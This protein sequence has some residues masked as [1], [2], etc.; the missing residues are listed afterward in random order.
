MIRLLVAELLQTKR[1][2]LIQ[3]HE[4]Q[5]TNTAVYVFGIVYN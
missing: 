1:E 5:L 3:S 2:I 4:L